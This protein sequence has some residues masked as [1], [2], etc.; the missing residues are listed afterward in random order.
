MKTVNNDADKGTSSCP[1]QSRYYS[2][3]FVLF[4][5]L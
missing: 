4:F 1:I 2:G 3:F 5:L